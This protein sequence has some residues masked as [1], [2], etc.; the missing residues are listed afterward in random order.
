MKNQILP[1][2]KIA[3]AVILAATCI[4]SSALAESVDYSRVLQD[5]V[6]GQLPTKQDMLGWR[7]GRCYPSNS[8][9]K[10]AHMIATWSTGASD[11]SF[12]A[13]FI[14]ALFIRNISTLKSDSLDQLTYNVQEAVAKAFEENGH[15]GHSPQIEIQSQKFDLGGLEIWVRKSGSR[16]VSQMRY[17]D[18]SSQFCEAYLLIKEEQN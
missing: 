5:W 10:Y 9:A 4:S 12:Q 15:S 3:F 1:K 18:G 14:Q 11:T 13:L 2:L 7:S 17:Q 16:L 6:N 8:L